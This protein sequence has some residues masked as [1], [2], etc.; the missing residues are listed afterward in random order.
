MSRLRLSDPSAGFS[1]IE[2]MVALV[3]LAVGMLAAARMFAASV[4]LSG[5]A[6]VLTE[7]GLA[8]QAIAETGRAAGCQPFNGD[9]AAGA[10]TLR[11]A[12][13]GS[14]THRI[15]V[16]VTSPAGDTLHTHVVTAFEACAP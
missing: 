7:A 4:G 16:R 14:A 5:R 12:S 11:W 6:R 8:A 1:L 9:S 15:E 10:L 2:V 13:A 3:L